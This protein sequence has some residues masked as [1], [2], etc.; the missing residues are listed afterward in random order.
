MIRDFIFSFFS[1][2][3]FTFNLLIAIGARILFGWSKLSYKG[4][5][6]EDDTKVRC[7]SLP[8]FLLDRIDSLHPDVRIT[9]KQI[10][11]DKLESLSDEALIK[12]CRQLEFW[13]LNGELNLEEMTNLTQRLVDQSLWYRDLIDKSASSELSEFK[14]PTTRF[15]KTE[16]QISL[17]TCGCMRFQNTWMMDFV[18]LL[19]PNR[20]HV[21]K[22]YP[23]ENIKNCL[24]SCFALGINHVET[25]RFYGTSEYQIV[26]ALYELIEEGK[27]KRTDFIFQTKIGAMNKKNFLKFWNQSW[28]N[29]EK[30]L[31]YIDLFSLHC[32]AEVDDALYE[33]LDICE[34]LKK[35]GKIRHIGF[36]THG[37]S[38]KIM[39]LINTERF[40]YVNL[41]EHYFGSYHGSGT[42]D[43]K[44]GEGNLACVKRALELDMGVFQISPMD[45]GGKLYRP[46]KEVALLIGKDLTPIGFAL[47][48]AWKKVGFHTSSVGLARP[49]DLDEVMGAVRMMNLAKQ[50]KID[51][52]AILDDVIDRLDTHLDEKLGKEWTEKGL[53]ELPTMY[54][55]VTDGIAVGHILW[56]HNLLMGYGMYEFCRAM[57]VSL[58]CAE[59]NKKKSFAENE[60]K[61]NRANPGRSFDQSVDL[62]KALENHYNPSLALA[63]IKELHQYLKGTDDM[64]EEQQQENGWYKGYNLT[65]WT[66]M[67]GEVDSRSLNEVLLQNLTGGRMGIQNTGPGDSFKAEANQL[68]EAIGS[69]N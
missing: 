61:I 57:Y 48:F 58:E 5:N 27:V 6:H 54:D 36:S 37:T 46:S 21:L 4:N 45:K 40:E 69:P 11:K 14:V 65:V 41:H 47:L 56:L 31:G 30:K 63:K 12:I 67:P 28:S 55:E 32:I 49:S 2:A 17:V 66:E 18:P 44:E 42:P 29:I 24:R 64:T 9:M 52:D 20:T 26:E 53:L 19:R 3:Q 15:G 38:Q 35:K 34:D 39:D 50:G 68:R 25:A 33:S 60:K 8:T 22:G 43:T 62:T 7:I 13:H 23:Q 59:W 1:N 10:L 16:L 51:I